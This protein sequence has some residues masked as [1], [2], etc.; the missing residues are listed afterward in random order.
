LSSPDSTTLAC[1]ANA[2]TIPAFFSTARSITAASMPASSCSR[3]SAR[4]AFIAER[5]PTLGMRRCSGIWPP[6][7]PTL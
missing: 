1:S 5:K 7:K 2:F 3:T 4:V 6:S